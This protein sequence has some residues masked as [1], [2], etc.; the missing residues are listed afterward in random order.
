MSIM[1]MN[2]RALHYLQKR[3]SKKPLTIWDFEAIKLFF[4][5]IDQ[6]VTTEPLLSLFLAVSTHN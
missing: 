2:E 5:Y 6:F 1:T 4:F 3:Q